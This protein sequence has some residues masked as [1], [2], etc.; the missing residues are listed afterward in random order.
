MPKKCLI[1]EKEIQ[2]DAIAA[3]NATFWTTSGNYGSGVYDPLNG[4]VFLEA[5]ICD[6]CLLRKKELIEEVVVIQPSE[7]IERR[8]V[9]F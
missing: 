1:C 2:V 7:I 5:I 6:E 8:P 3:Y 9:D 4:R